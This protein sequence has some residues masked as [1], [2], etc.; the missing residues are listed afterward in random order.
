MVAE[1]SRELITTGIG[2]VPFADVD[3]AVEYSLRH[4]IPFLPELTA[5]GD[6]MLEYA[7]HPGRL[8]SLRAFHRLR[9]AVAKVQCIGPATL[10]LSGYSEDDA[11]SIAYRH[12]DAIF[13]GLVADAILLF[14][15]EPALGSVGFD[16]VRLWEPLFETF[17]AVRGVHTCGNMQWDQLAKAPI[18]ILSFDASRYR[19]TKQLPDD[20]SVRLSWGIRAAEDVRAFRPGDLLTAPC[21]MP[22][23]AYSEQDAERQLELLQATAATLRPTAA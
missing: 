21:G 20:R 19:I 8:S 6:R 10:I 14:L 1:R 4:D 9:F 7:K 5:R 2:S 11:I 12:L 15:D 18:Q 17:P 13:D 3:R 16:Y 22:H 23:T